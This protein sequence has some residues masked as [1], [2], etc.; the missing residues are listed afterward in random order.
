MTHDV[1]SEQRSDVLFCALI[2]LS[3]FF[4][5]FFITLKVEPVHGEFLYISTF[6]HPSSTPTHLLRVSGWRGG[7]SPVS[8]TQSFTDKQASFTPTSDLDQP[9]KHSLRLYGRKVEEPEKPLTQGEQ[10]ADHFPG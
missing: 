3:L 4:S 2:S 8:Q 7:G 5:F 10:T 6:N 1:L 9:V